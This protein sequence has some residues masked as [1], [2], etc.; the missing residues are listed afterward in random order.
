M[1][2]LWF[3]NNL[4]QMCAS[5]YCW[6][7][8]ETLPKWP[9]LYFEVLSI[10]S[11]ERY[12]TEGYGYMT[13]P[14]KPGKSVRHYHKNQVSLSD[15][16]THMVIVSSMTYSHGDCIINDIHIH[17]VIVSSMTCSHG[18]CIINNIFTWW[19]YYQWHTHTHTVIL[20]SMTISH[21]DYIINVWYRSKDAYN[22]KNNENN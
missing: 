3:C 8:T 20:S 22:Q 18:D 17:T 13:L 21:A 6:S 10:D 19:F 11:W 15:T 5:I 4:I 14:Q 7:P 12:R 1:A 9:M 16:Y 2:R